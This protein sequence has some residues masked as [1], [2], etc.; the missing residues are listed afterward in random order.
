MA[1]PQFSP[2]DIAIVVKNDEFIEKSLHNKKCKITDYVSKY[3]EYSVI[4]IEGDRN[5]ASIHVG[6]EYLVS[7]SE[8]KLLRT[9]DDNEFK[10]YI[11]QM[12]H[13]KKIQAELFKK[14]FGLSD[15]TPLL[16]GFV[17]GKRV[18]VVKHNPEWEFWTQP[19]NFMNGAVGTVVGVDAKKST[20]TE[21]TFDV[22]K[23]EFVS[24][25]LFYE[26]K[27]F[28]YFLPEHLEILP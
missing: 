12:E 20:K 15:G 1:K 25:Q 13:A 21:K 27:Y 5:G 17:S 16:M 22:I 24:M 11:A 8:Y 9:I 19:M 26:E 14:A 10:E 18:R 4:M 3:D 2:N 28:H 23:V 7:E 6:A